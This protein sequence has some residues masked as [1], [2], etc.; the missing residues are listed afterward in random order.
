MNDAPSDVNPT[1]ETTQAKFRQRSWVT[2]LV[3]F[4]LLAAY[5]VLLCTTA[6]GPL[7]WSGAA[8]TS[9]WDLQDRGHLQV[10]GGRLLLAG[11][12]AIAQFAVVAFLICL[13]SGRRR[14]WLPRIGQAV[15]VLAIGVVLSAVVTYVRHR[16]LQQGTGL[17]WPLV[18]CGL[19]VWLGGAWLR[20]PRGMMWLVPQLLL[21]LLLLGGGVLGLA[22]LSLEEAPLSFEPGQVNS[23]EKR[24]LVSLIRSSRS[25]RP[26]GAGTGM[27][28][29]TERDAD[30]LMAWGLSLGTM[31]RKAR[32]QFE[33]G[34]ALADLSMGVPIGPARS[35]YVNIQLAGH[36]ELESGHVEARVDQCQLG[37]L[38]WPPWLVKVI[39]APVVSAVLNDPD[40]AQAMGSLKSVKLLTNQVDVVYG[41]GLFNRRVLP[42][43]IS[44]LGANPDI[45]EATK[46]HVVYLVSVGRQLP[47]GDAR[48]GAFVQ[49][50]FGFAQSR[51]AD[52]NAQ[53][54]NRAAIC[55]LG[56]LLGHRH[57]ERLL[58]VVTDAKLRRQAR[59]NVRNVTLRGRTDWTKHFWVSAALALMSSE[60]A[61][62]AIGL[63]KEELDADFRG[64][65]FSFADLMADRAGTLFALA[66]TRDEQAARAMQH[67]L[68]EGLRVDDVFPAAHD[69]PEGLTDA[70]LQ[71]GYGGVGGE[72]YRRLIQQI[73]DRLAACEALR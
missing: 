67:R 8:D 71:S 55:A 43:L 30:I 9:F 70:Q 66:V 44:R 47:Q 50:A 12:L 14:R 37:R 10:W 1:S 51:T 62:D 52:G 40:V 15:T 23:Q 46:A 45:A 34:Q 20:G 3:A 13:I 58:G 39:F 64:S 38:R 5:L 48:F 63:L 56:V 54:E 59:R 19:G 33:T 36:F 42:T 27:L 26:H 6:S 18:G 61:S 49:A 65:G 29:L 11:A 24:R 57:I 73:E 16:D 68:A 25:N 60:A 28:R 31:Q 17:I 22:W 32:V 72:G 41:K 21:L 7:Q 53:A 4:L 2:G 35:R 69:L